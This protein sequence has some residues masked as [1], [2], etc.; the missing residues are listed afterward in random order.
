M[1]SDLA[2]LALVTC[3]FGVISKT[4][5]PRPTLQRSTPLLSSRS[6]IILV[7]IFRSQSLYIPWKH[8]GL[9]SRREFAKL[10]GM[11]ALMCLDVHCQIAFK[12][13]R[14][15]ILLINKYERAHFI[16]HWKALLRFLLILFNEI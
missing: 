13:G 2:L 12:R 3:L 11:K 9:F 1:K 10:N 6:F 15:N 14:T 7:S 8:L 16:V 5:L 4:P